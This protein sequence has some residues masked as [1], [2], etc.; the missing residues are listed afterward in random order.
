MEILS[1]FYEGA[2][3]AAGFVSFLSV[4]IIVGTATFAAIHKIAKWAGWAE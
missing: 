3:V 2:T 1:Y 4:V